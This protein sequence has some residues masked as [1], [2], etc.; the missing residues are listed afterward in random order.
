VKSVP[1]IG[2]RYGR[3]PC[4]RIAGECCQI[5][6]YDWSLGSNR[7]LYKKDGHKREMICSQ[8]KWG[9]AL[10]QPIPTCGSCAFVRFP[11]KIRLPARPPMPFSIRAFRRFPVQCS[12]LYNSGPFQG[13]G[14]VSNLS[15]TGGRL[16]GDLPMGP[17]EILSLTVTI[18]NEQR[19]EVPEVVERPGVC[20]GQCDDRATHSCSAPALREAAGAKHS[21]E[22]IFGEIRDLRMRR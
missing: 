11:S 5:S 9:S 8:I 17:G 15:G 16:S 12:V 3:G 21:R 4:N 22:S 13:Q 10:R 6:L 14:S 2:V 7:I 19:I 20:G 1:M 18:P